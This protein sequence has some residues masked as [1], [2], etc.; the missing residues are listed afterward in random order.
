MTK[1]SGIT[2]PLILYHRGFTSFLAWLTPQQE[3]YGKVIRAKAHRQL[4][5][6]R[7]HTE[8]ALRKLGS[9]T[10]VYCQLNQIEWNRTTCIGALATK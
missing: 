6:Q 10:L 9:I 8:S 1:M 7:L 3:F 4:V 5:H 2:S